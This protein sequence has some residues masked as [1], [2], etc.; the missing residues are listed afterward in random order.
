MAL[1]IG[2][3]LWLIMRQAPASERRHARGVFGESLVLA[4]VRGHRRTATVH[5]VGPLRSLAA[6][7]AWD[8]GPLSR[9]TLPR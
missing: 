8:G 9:L 7:A 3:A 2:F 1:V 5:L 4:A 6:V